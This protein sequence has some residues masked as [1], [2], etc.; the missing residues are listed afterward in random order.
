MNKYNT[1]EI[2]DSSL[3]N[4]TALGKKLNELDDLHQN[5]RNSIS[6]TSKIPA[7]FIDLSRQVNDSTKDYLSGNNILFKECILAIENKL[8]DL[9]IINLEF[10][11]EVERIKKVDLESHFDKHQGKLSEIFNLIKIVQ[12]SFFEL[13]QKFLT[14]SNEVEKIESVLYNNQEN[15]L[16]EFKTIKGEFLRIKDLISEKLKNIENT[17]DNNQENIFKEFKIIKGEFLRLKDLISEKMQNIENAIDNNQENILKEF[18]I[19]KAEFPKLNDHISDK[20]QNMENR[21]SYLQQ[22]IEALKNNISKNHK[23]QN[24]LIVIVLVFLTSIAC[25]VFLFL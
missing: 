3:N 19:I 12:N 4:V 14:L 25:K 6:E 7:L 5:I 9:E 10:E 21:V 20:L 11:K 23:M 16:R 1:K 2:I 8:I 17:I 15:I 24:I 18:K 22:S 13:C